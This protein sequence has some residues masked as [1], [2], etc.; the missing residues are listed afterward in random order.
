ML[1][2][3][4]LYL[5]VFRN[6]HS[7][8]AFHISLALCAQVSCSS[9]S[10]KLVALLRAARLRHTKALFESTDPASPEAKLLKHEKNCERMTHTTNSFYT[11][12]AVAVAEC[13]PLGVHIR[14]FL[15]FKYRRIVCFF[16]VLLSQRAD[17][18]GDIMATLPLITSWSKC[19]KIRQTDPPQ[20]LPA[21]R[22]CIDPVGVSVPFLSS[23]NNGQ[24]TCQCE[25]FATVQVPLKAD[26][27][28]QRAQ[29]DRSRSRC[30]C[31]ECTY[32][33]AHI[34]TD[35]RNFMY[36]CAQ[37]SFCITSVVVPSIGAGE[38]AEL[39]ARGAVLLGTR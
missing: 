35:M 10:I 38:G 9:L 37:A 16:A 15:P 36:K 12:V 23:C 2:I 32:K 18:N 13:I 3:Q 17:S 19:A 11:G 7:F 31:A 6:V 28:D 27:E 8:A 26:K 39:K 29:G 20:G 21:V 22:L 25:H 24:S 34:H 4:L 30:A 1:P 33:C 5:Y 14:H